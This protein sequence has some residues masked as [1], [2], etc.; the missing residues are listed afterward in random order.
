MNLPDK[1]H[2]DT[3]HDPYEGSELQRDTERAIDR[4][5][6][7]RDERRDNAPPPSG[8]SGLSECP[9]HQRTPYG[10]ANVSMSQLSIARHY[11]G[12]TYSGDSY[13]Y[14]P[15]T[16]ELIRNDVLKWQSN[17]AKKSAKRPEP[18]TL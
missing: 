14:L 16:D 9:L 10:M 13:T 8:L 2:Y 7:M 1:D 12:I 4:A 18:P 15:K 6:Q 11:G 5:D 3:S 17:Q